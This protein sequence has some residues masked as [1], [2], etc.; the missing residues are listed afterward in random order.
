MMVEICYNV[1][2]YEIRDPEDV[3]VRVLVADPKGSLERDLCLANTA[4][5]LNNCPLAVILIRAQGDPLEKL[6]QDW[7]TPDEHFISTKRDY[8]FTLLK[9]IESGLTSSILRSNRTTS[10][11]P[12]SAANDSGVWPSHVAAVA[13]T[14]SLVSSERTTSPP[15][16]A[17]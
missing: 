3:A 5:T 7:F 11:C 14:S 1:V 8:E 4:E 9:Y 16:S 17:A 13:S 6:V 12:L 10:S 15:I 2:N